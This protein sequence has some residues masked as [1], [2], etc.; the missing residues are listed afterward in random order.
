M[1]SPEATKQFEEMP[2]YSTHTHY[3]HVGVTL[4]PETRKR[5]AELHAKR[6]TMDVNGPGW[7]V[8]VE[9]RAGAT[10]EKVPLEE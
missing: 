2:S 10:P 6:S 7:V 3:Q 8:G 1:N 9:G 5:L 4:Y